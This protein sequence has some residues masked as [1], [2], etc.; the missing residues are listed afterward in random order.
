MWNTHPAVQNLPS[1][2]DPSAF[3]LRSSHDLLMAMLVA[4]STE[5]P[6]PSPS[7]S[8]GAQAHRE[9]PHSPLPLSPPPQPYFHMPLDSFISQWATTMA[10]NGG[11]LLLSPLLPQ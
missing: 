2:P 6:F 5:S 3:S 8:W 11:A 10:S 9:A 4:L 1:T 7:W